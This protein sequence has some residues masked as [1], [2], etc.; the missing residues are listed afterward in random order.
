LCNRL[1][2][3]EANGWD[4]RQ[5]V[6]MIGGDIKGARSVVDLLLWRARNALPDWPPALP[7]PEVQG[8]I[9][10]AAFSS[11]FD[12]FFGRSTAEPSPVIAV[13]SKEFT[14]SPAPAPPDGC[15][16]GLA[17]RMDGEGRFH[18]SP[19]PNHGRIRP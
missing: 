14:P 8:P 6:A 12:S 15:D 19:C 7:R 9:P 11:L 10:D 18:V 3:L 1:Q 17:E 4:P 13:A 16:Q 2:E 5:L